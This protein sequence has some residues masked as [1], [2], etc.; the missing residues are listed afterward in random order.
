MTKVKHYSCKI[1]GVSTYAISNISA[2]EKPLVDFF[3]FHPASVKDCPEQPQGVMVHYIY[4]P[5]VYTKEAVPGDFMLM[6]C[7]ED[8]HP[9]RHSAAEACLA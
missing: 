7:M 6:Y 8:V 5:F 9:A 1:T 4:I 3:P 2:S